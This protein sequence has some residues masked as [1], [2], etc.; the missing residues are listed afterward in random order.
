MDADLDSYATTIY[1]T[2][3]GLADLQYYSF[4]LQTIRR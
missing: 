2:V 1:V 3:G 4:L